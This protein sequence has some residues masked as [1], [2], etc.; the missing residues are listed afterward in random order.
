MELALAAVL[1]LGRQ[2]RVGI[3]VGRSRPERAALVTVK[4]FAEDMGRMEELFV[5]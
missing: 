1:A 5:R 2:L 3:R 4:A